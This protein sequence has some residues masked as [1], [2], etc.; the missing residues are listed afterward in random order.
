MLLMFTVRPRP[1]R[2]TEIGL[3]PRGRMQRF[4]NVKG[5]VAHSITTMLLR[6]QVFKF[7]A[8]WDVTSDSVHSF[9]SREP[10]STDGLPIQHALNLHS[11][12]SSYM[13]CS[14]LVTSKRNVFLRA[15]EYRIHYYTS[16][17]LREVKMLGDS[18]YLRSDGTVMI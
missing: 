8:S 10:C 14:A 3:S 15:S 1:A 12:I 11:K 13:G 5:S 2:Y 6:V 9:S 4:F 7:D 16:F 18:I 17:F